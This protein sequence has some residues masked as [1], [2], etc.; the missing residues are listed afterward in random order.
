MSQTRYV[1]SV[2]DMAVASDN[3]IRLV[4]TSPWECDI[5]GYGHVARQAL[6][7]CSNAQ[8]GGIEPLVVRVRVPRSSCQLGRCVAFSG[9]G[10]VS[11]GRDIHGTSSPDHPHGG[12]RLCVNFHGGTAF[13]DGN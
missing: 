6:Y 12:P 9:M 3:T 7:E 8:Y 10:E 11:I 5:P 1:H 2:Y 13:V 4:C